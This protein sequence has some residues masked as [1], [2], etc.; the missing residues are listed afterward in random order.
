MNVQRRLKLCIVASGILTAV[1]VVMAFTYSST[2]G[3]FSFGPNDNLVI[4]GIPINTTTRYAVL[5]AIIVVNS[6]V[7]LVVQEFA[8]P[9][10]GFNIYNPDKHVITDFASKT[11]LQFLASMF[12][13]TT[14]LRAVF[15][16]LVSITQ[17]DLAIIKWVALELTAIATVH[18]LLSEKKFVSA[19]GDPESEPFMAHVGDTAV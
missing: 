8:N 12:W 10:M 16:I 4:S 5:V 15:S 14:N 13:A 1:I 19:S 6:V 18:F 11:Q 2:S 9:I 7:D 3:W 17:V